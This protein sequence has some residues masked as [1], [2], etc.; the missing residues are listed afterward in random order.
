MLP[1]SIF[2]NMK[3]TNKLFV[4]LSSKC[5]AGKREAGSCR[6]N[7]ANRKDSHRHAG[8]KIASQNDFTVRHSRHSRR[9]DDRHRVAPKPDGEEEPVR[10]TVVA[11]ASNA[12]SGDASDERAT[13]VVRKE[14][15]SAAKADRQV[16]R[17]RHSGHAFKVSLSKNL[18]NN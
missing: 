6:Q 9:G 16:W 10:Q 13:Q 15:D 12:G 18:I 2:S 8:R 5:I 7:L 3:E 11:V 17:V 4:T 14:H 1:F